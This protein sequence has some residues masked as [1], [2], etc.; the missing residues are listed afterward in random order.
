[1][2]CCKTRPVQRGP[3]AWANT[4]LSA[5]PPPW[6]R[7]R[8]GPATA[9]SGAGQVGN[10]GLGQGQR[11]ETAKARH[12]WRQNRKAPS[13]SFE[14]RQEGRT[15]LWRLV[16]Q[17]QGR[18]G[19]CITHQHTPFADLNELRCNRHGAFKHGATRSVHSGFA[20]SPPQRLSRK[21]SRCRPCTTRRTP[22]VL[23]AVGRPYP[24]T[25]SA[26]PQNAL[27]PR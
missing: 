13:K 15:A 16:Q 6:A 20:C 4:A 18:A 14:P 17:H 10:A 12:V 22:G 24:H 3:S 11:V 25:E 26:K 23:R 27:R 19:A 8:R 21:H 7:S 5:Q 9:S 2:G 1:M